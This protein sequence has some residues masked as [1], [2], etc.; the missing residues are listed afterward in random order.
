MS[1]VLAIFI[2]ECANSPMQSVDSAHLEAGKGVV[3]DRYYSESGTFSEKL[4]GLPDKEI[5]LIEAEQVDHFN[6]ECGFAFRYSDFRRNVVTAGVRL[7]ELEGKEFSVGGVR[8][9]G[10]RLCEPCAHLASVLVPEILPAMAHRAGL[11]AQI[12][13]DGR[14]QTGALIVEQ[15]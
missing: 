9:K 14:I 8:L 3:G 13:S 5:T 12:L 4:A 10:V 6:R 1:K 11:R 2:A 7:N 15:N